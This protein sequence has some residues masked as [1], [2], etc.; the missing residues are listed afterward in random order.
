M[1]QEAQNNTVPLSEYQIIQMAQKQFRCFLA[2]VWSHLGLPMPTQ[3]QIEI[4]DYLHDNLCILYR[5][6]KVASGTLWTA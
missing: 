6:M 4:A 3:T 1:N 2:L 5:K